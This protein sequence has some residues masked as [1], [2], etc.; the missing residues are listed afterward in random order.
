MRALCSSAEIGDSILLISFVDFQVKSSEVGFAVFITFN[1]EEMIHPG[2]P[3]KDF[4]Y[5][6][7]ISSSRLH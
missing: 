5:K 7:S 4:K 3:T 1:K 2:R 6:L